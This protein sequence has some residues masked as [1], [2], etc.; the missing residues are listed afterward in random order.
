MTLEQIITDIKNKIYKP[1][2]LL[3]GDEPYYIDKLCDFMEENILEESEKAFNQHIYYGKDISVLDIDNLARRF[4]MM[5]NHQLVIIKEAQDVKKIEDLVHYVSN[6]LKSTILVLNYKYKKLGSKRKFYNAIKKEGLIFES[7]KLY[8]D[9][10]PAWI[11][12][13]LNKKKY[14][15]D[16]RSSFLLSESLGNDLT[17]I[18]HELDKLVLS[19]SNNERT[20]TAKLIEQNIGISKDFNNFELQNALGQKNVLKAN[21]IIKYFGN[22]QKENP[23]ILTVISL[24][25]YFTK[26]LMYYFIKDKSNKNVATILK[27]HPFFVKDYQLAARNYKASKLVSIISLLREY[28][29]KAKGVNAD[30]IP[31]SE[32]LKEMVYKILH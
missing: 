15:I 26:I 8:D 13:Y 30:S 32:L 3:T 25:S 23:F 7:K 9:K 24:Y 10:I 11:T 16:T 19:L 14:N 6:P 1:V 22:N 27:I 18:S 21:Q 17:K 20:I 2:Y 31:A 28:D 29:L 4:P 5:A 12:N